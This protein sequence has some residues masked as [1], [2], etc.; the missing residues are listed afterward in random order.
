MLDGRDLTGATI[1]IVDCSPI[2]VAW[3][4]WNNSP[5]SRRVENEI[6]IRSIA[7]MKSCIFTVL[8]VLYQLWLITRNVIDRTV[9]SPGLRMRL[10]AILLTLG[11]RY[12][13]KHSNWACLRFRDD[14]LSWLLLCLSLFSRMPSLLSLLLL[15]LN[16]TLCLLTSE[17]CV[18][19]AALFTC[20]KCFR[21]SVIV[22]A[23]LHIHGVFERSLKSSGVTRAGVT[24]CFNSWC[25]PM[26]LLPP[27]MPYI[28]CLVL[29]SNTSF[30]DSFAAVIADTRKP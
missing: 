29:A 14:P 9:D 7:E 15:L 24:Q 8:Q 28:T 25:H 6:C 30:P 26:Y 20:M 27:T 12:I 23:V 3:C 17:D 21:V 13:H 2:D 10:V 4:H 5:R 18:S 22:T 16:S 1:Y 19:A 11:C